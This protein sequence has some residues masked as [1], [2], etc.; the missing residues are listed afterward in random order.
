MDKEEK[1]QKEYMK[2]LG[3]TQATYNEC[4]QVVVTS[5]EHLENAR[6][7]MQH[8]QNALTDA[9]NKLKNARV[10]LTALMDVSTGSNYDKE[11]ILKQEG[12][13]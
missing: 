8:I 4:V 12:L 2:L 1:T 9:E 6:K 11:K 13:M 7:E 10:A 5:K 3:A